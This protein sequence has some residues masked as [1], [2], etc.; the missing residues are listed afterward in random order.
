M[1]GSWLIASVCTDRMRQRSSATA[2]VCGKSSLNSAPDSP[3]FANLKIVGAT[4]RLFCPEV[5]VV[6]RCPI[7]TESGSSIPRLPWIA[8]LLSNRSSCD[9]APDW[10]R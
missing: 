10:N 2:A 7:R 4:G 5:I 1:A 3:Y 6:I 8:G 9:G